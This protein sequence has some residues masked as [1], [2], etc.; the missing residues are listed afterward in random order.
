MHAAEDQRAPL[1]R[2]M[3]APNVIT[4]LLSVANSGPA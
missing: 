1:T 4:D 2:L 3:K